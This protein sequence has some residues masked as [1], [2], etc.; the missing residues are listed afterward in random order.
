MT[1]AQEKLL[2]ALV[3]AQVAVFEHIH[4][5]IGIPGRAKSALL[6]CLKVAVRIAKSLDA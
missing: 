2:G 5:D 6:E 1:D 3:A 4:E